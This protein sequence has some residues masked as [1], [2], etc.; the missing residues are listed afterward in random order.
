MMQIGT[1]R[2]FD[3]DHDIFRDSVRKFFNEHIVPFHDKWEEDG[4]IAREAWIEAGNQG[5][6][7]VTMPEEYG[8]LGADILYS[9]I[10]WEEQSYSGCTG[11]GFALHSEI[12]APYFLKFGS[13][14][15][16]ERI[17]PEL[18]SGKGISAIA[19]TEPG[20]GSDLQGIRTNAV[21]DGD[22]WILNGS[23]TYIT[24]G[25]MADYV[26]VVA[27]TDA[28]KGAHGISLFVVEEGMAGFNRGRK[29]KKLGLKAQD[30]SEL[31]FDN[32]RLPASAMLGKEN[33]GFYMLMQELPQERLLI[34]DMA[35]A[36]AE[37][38]YEWTREYVKNRKAFGKTLDKL[39][40]I[41]HKLAEVKTETAVG[42][43][44]LDQCLE[45][46]AAGKLDNSTASMA[47]YWATD[48][49]CKIADD[50]LQLH[51][52]AGFM[53]EYPICRGYADARVQRIYGGSNEIM[54]EL[55]ARDI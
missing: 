33:H 38:S 28:S 48:L 3:S 45:L 7:A 35:V 5:M 22:D 9:A 44:F 2:I 6:L 26:I 40:T 53:W 29:L 50:C 30:T 41:R 11:P 31:F 16:K 37:A 47:K 18:I 4:Q 21:R 17:I 13:Q 14:E 46:H 15:Q 43:A 49:Q 1:R 23:K 39:Q 36:A 12:C 55:I 24:N 51:G 54:K 42:R 25:A 20:A 8:G 27:K 52:G 19:M 32:V 10:I 34:A